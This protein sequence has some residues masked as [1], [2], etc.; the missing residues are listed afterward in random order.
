MATKLERICDTVIARIESGALR[1]GDQLPSE[2]Q[3]AASL[4]ASVGTIQKALAASAVLEQLPLDMH[5]Y[6]LGTLPPIAH[7]LNGS[8]T[9]GFLFDC[10]TPSTHT[11]AVLELRQLVEFICTTERGPV[12]VELSE[13]RGVER[14][15][16]GAGTS[17]GQQR[18][19]P[20]RPP[21]VGRIVEHPTDG[22]GPSSR[23]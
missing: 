4:K 2:E 14:N 8:T 15:C 12:H 5:G 1:E 6:Y 9:A 22:F 21:W 18:E 19:L 20:L 23:K 16:R 7:E 3:L 17:V 10:G 11:N 13:H